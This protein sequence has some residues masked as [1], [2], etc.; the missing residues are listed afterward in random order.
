M[1]KAASIDFGHLGTAEQA[2]NTIVNLLANV[3]AVNSYLFTHPADTKHHCNLFE[4]MCP[5]DECKSKIDSPFISGL[6]STNF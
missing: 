5:P 3:L 1:F 2:E 6:I 4:V